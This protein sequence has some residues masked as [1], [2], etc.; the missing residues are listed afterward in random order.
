ME[1][2]CLMALCIGTFGAE[3]VKLPVF[4]LE[5]TYWCLLALVVCY[6]YKTLLKRELRIQQQDWFLLAFEG[7][8]CVVVALSF[9]GIWQKLAGNLEN[10]LVD[11]HYIPRQAYYLALMPALFFA[12]PG[13]GTDWVDTRLQ[14]H[15]RKLFFVVYFLN[16]LLHRDFVFPV[17]SVFIL[18]FLSL[19]EEKR[20][21]W[22]WLQFILIL[23]SV[24][25]GERQITTLLVCFIYV[26]CFLLQKKNKLVFLGLAAGIWVCVGVCFLAPLF[27]ELIGKIISDP[28]TL[29]RAEFWADEMNLLADSRFLG[30]GFGTAYCSTDFIDPT[31]YK[32][33]GPGAPFAATAQ[34]SIYDKVFVTGA[35][36][37]F[38]TVAFRMGLMGIVLLVGYLICLQCKQMRHLDQ[39]PLNSIYTMCASITMIALNV[40]LESPYYAIL[41]LFGICQAA[42]HVKKVADPTKRE[43]TLC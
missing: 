40:G 31:S 41:F 20:D 26:I 33:W 30:V 13:K 29:W 34:Y 7:Y 2:I 18:C 38:V 8:A 14:R 36:N 25:L 10:L 43:E 37:S 12:A 39:V 22:D 28:N 17:T 35:H 15:S 4:G 5:M 1:I 21:K 3:F 16:A 42:Y 23:L 19:R 27:E 32:P 9:V 6:G 11:T 24:W